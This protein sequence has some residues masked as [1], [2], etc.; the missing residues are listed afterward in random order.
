LHAIA[1]ET[2]Q[3]VNVVGQDFIGRSLRAFEIDSASAV[4]IDFAKGFVDRCQQP[5]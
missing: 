5:H 3:R 2:A 1:E 4:K